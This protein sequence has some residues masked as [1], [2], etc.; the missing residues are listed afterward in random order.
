MKEIF[1][2]NGDFN[3]NKILNKI[4]VN[5]FNLVILDRDKIRTELNKNKESWD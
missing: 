1:K 3:K 4:F 2:I 5:F